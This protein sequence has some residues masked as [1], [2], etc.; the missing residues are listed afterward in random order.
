[1]VAR[2]PFRPLKYFQDEIKYSNGH[3]GSVVNHNIDYLVL[4]ENNKIKFRFSY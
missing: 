4:G 2:A 1:M 3:N